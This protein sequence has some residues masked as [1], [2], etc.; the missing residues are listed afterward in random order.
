MSSP[1]KQNG[2]PSHPP[3]GK[4]R[5]SIEQDRLSEAF[6]VSEELPAGFSKFVP[7]ALNKLRISRAH[8]KDGEKCSNMKCGKAF[9]SK[10]ATK[11]CF[12]CGYPYCRACL[13]CKRKLG[14]NAKPSPVGIECPVC[15]RCSQ[16]GGLAQ[17]LGH[18]YSHTEV[19][20]GFRRQSRAH[21]TKQGPT[22]SVQ[23]LN[24][25]HHGKVIASQ[26]THLTKEF[27]RRRSLFTS[28]TTG[29]PDW[30]KSSLWPHQEDAKSCT[31]CKKGLFLKSKIHCRLCGLIHC[32]NC[33]LQEH[34]LLYINIRSASTWAIVGCNEPPE[35]PKKYA[36]FPA[37]KGCL[38][39]LE[40]FA[41]P[42][43]EG[44]DRSKEGTDADAKDEQTEVFYLKII[45]H[46]EQA[47]KHQTTI[48]S[49]LPR[50]GE[51]I[52]EEEEK[53]QANGGK[54]PSEV[55]KELARLHCDLAKAFKD[56]RD[57]TLTIKGV[58]GTTSRQDRLKQNVMLG[59]QTYHSNNVMSYR[60]HLTRVQSILPQVDRADEQVRDTSCQALKMVH[61]LITQLVMELFRMG[62]KYPHLSGMLECE[63]TVHL[64]GIEEVVAEELEEVLV[65]S[66]NTL[67]E[68]RKVAK[69]FVRSEFKDNH[70]KYPSIP[71]ECLH[72]PPAVKQHVLR[73]SQTHL[74]K[75]RRHLVTSSAASVRDF[76]M[77]RD[78]I[79][80]KL[81]DFQSMLEFCSL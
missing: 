10:N 30:Q 64:K 61:M 63:I 20:E 27:D 81:L 71:P 66:G 56:H 37:C 15:E 43:E 33:I 16:D 17:S 60:S 19:F 53:Q 80:R 4:W 40:P 41:Q 7:S 48:S 38:G 74:N 59:C 28:M 25:S 55:P 34:L 50:Y 76:R 39:Q 23:F 18:E 1:G 75:C 47:M 22:S 68:H 54:R 32:S 35:K 13:Q 65:E 2:A 14:A 70:F 21:P 52:D 79:E 73:F 11:H 31:N 9:A 8:W 67:D 5:D 26:L 77:S 45:H 24:R 57:T 44:T 69:D 49:S 62:D 72:S 29:V 58:Q 12:L 46:Q 36:T 3:V 6:D 51:L 42:P 78:I